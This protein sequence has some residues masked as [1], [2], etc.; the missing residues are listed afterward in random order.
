MFSTDNISK[1]IISLQLIVTDVDGTMTDSG[2]YY[3]DHGNELKKFSTK[4]GVG[5]IAAHKAGMKI[6]VLTGREC[7][8]TI[9]R[10]TEL[11]AD[12]IFQNHNDKKK[13][14]LSFMADNH[15]DKSTVAYIGDDVN[16]LPAMSVCG[17]KACPVDSS[18]EIKAIADYVSPV[19]GGCGAVR[20]VIEHILR[21]G[22][23]WD[24]VI[25][26]CFGQ[27]GI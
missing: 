25:E 20:D 22:G 1:S 8:A 23:I 12:Y 27:A 14:L 6:M 5:F 4:D 15:I 3:D 7:K 19:K 2:V 16:D 21:E 9:R 18:K 10:M 11:K 24:T 13:F 26:Q 17:Y